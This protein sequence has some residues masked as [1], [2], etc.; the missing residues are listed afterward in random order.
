MSILTKRTAAVWALV[1]LLVPAAAWAQQ[2]SVTGAVLDAL[3]GRV[4]AATVTLTGQGQSAET[5]SGTDG[6]YTFDNVAPGRYQV[7][8]SATGFEP[9]SSAPVYVGPGS[10]VSINATLQVGPLSQAVVVTASASSISQSQTGAPV[11]VIDAQTLETLNKP[12]VQEALRLVP[13]AVILQTGARGGP[14]SFFVRGGTSNFNKVLVDGIV[15]NDIGGGF[16]FQYIQTAGLERVEVLRQSN[17][18]MYGTDALAG[19]VSFETRRGRTRVPELRYAI[20]GGNFGTFN[21]AL[22]VGGAV[23]RF[24]YFSEL[25]HFKTDNQ[26]P[27]NEYKNTSYAGRFGVMLGRGTDISGTLRHIDADAGSPNGFLYFGI[28]DDSTTASR[29]T[30]AGVTARSQWTNRLQTT[31]RFGSTDQTSEFANPTPTGFAYDPFG[32]GANYLGDTVTLR[33]ANGYS[34]TGRAILDFTDTYPSLFTSRTARQTLSGLSTLQVAGDFFVS[35]GARFER[36]QGF[37]DPDADPSLTRKNGGLFVEGRGSVGGRTYVTGGL[38]YEHNAVFRSAVVPR[39]SVASY[40]RNPA[41]GALGE[42]KLVFNAGTGIKAPAVYQQQSSLYELLLA[43]PAASRPTVD[44]V[45][46]ERSRS[47]DVGIEQG[48]SDGRARARVSYFFSRY[49]D[50]LEYVSSTVLPQLGVPASVAQAAG[51]GAYVNSSSFDAQGLETSGEAVIGGGF[52]VTASYMY[53][54]TEVTRSFTGSAL[55]PSINPAFPNIPIG[56][57]APL[58][59]GRAF[60]RPTHSGNVMGAYTRGPVDVAVTASFAGKRDGSTF[61][62]D[63][64]FGNSMLLPN[65]NLEPSYQKVDLSAGYRVHPRLR[66]YTTIENLFDQDYQAAF[67]YPSLPLAARFGASVSLGGN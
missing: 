43:V 23:K 33:G 52:K 57:F 44:P 11:T 19:V 62:S 38:G 35:G 27:N 40:L 32:F 58:V 8:A 20:D 59:G 22:S 6:T 53:L 14:S 7:V 37:N 36:E 16:D 25:T 61:L 50:L 60:R 9:F 48:F 54:D 30:Y 29:Q 64:F 45:G 2:G 21:N 12:D 42:T 51:F 4:A 17:S 39:L 67:G 55:A 5:K 31:V 18:V 46:P 26:T 34:T 15:A 66:L 41:L 56:A 47:V 49:T 13:G 65:A 10:R 24:D 1:A 3:G 28:A 63:Q